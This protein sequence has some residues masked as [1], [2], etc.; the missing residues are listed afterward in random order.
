MS[1]WLIAALVFSMTPSLWGQRGGFIGGGF[2]HGVGFPQS[3]GFGRGAVLLGDPWFNDYPAGSLAYAAPSPP[4]FIVQQ[5]AAEGSAPERAVEPLLIEWQVDRYVRVGSGQSSAKA[6]AFPDYSQAA[7]EAHLNSAGA[8]LTPQRR[9]LP[10]A[11]LIFRDGHHEQISEYV[12]ARGVLYARADYALTGL[13]T[14]DIELAT[15]DL[16]ATLKVNQENGLKFVLPNS[17]NEVVTRP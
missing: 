16:P 11:I 8:P 13:G 17:P 3:R 6:A 15:L 14:R 5:P 9:E 2:G 7:A 4:V 12:I 1:K 10:P